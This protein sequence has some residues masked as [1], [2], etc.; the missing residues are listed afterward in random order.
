MLR[1]RIHNTEAYIHL[2]CIHIHIH[3]ALSSHACDS[4]SMCMWLCTHVCVATYSHARGHVSKYE[5][6]SRVLDGP[7]SLPHQPLPAIQVTAHNFK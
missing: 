7:L 4:I 3:V 5:Y 2:S 6:V 1:S